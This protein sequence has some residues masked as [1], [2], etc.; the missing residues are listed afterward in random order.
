ME[1]KK[2]LGLFLLQ[3]F[4][5]GLTAC[6]INT[7][8]PQRL[9]A[10]DV[11]NLGKR[12]EDI[13]RLQVETWDTRDPENLREI[14]T[15]DIVHFDDHPA[16][17]GIDEVL[18]MA[19]M[20]FRSFSKW[21]MELGD[22]YISK[23]K[24]V[25]TWVSWDV[26]GFTQDNPGLE[27]DLLETQDNKISFWRLFYDENFGW[28]KID[29]ELLA[30]YEESWSQN[31]ESALLAIY[32]ENATVE[33]TLFGVAT[34][35]HQEIADYAKNIFAL[36]QEAVWKLIIPFAEGKASYP[37]SDEYPFPST[38]GVFGINTKKTDGTVCEIRVV[39][40]LTPNENGKIQ[41]QE[42]FYDANTL[43]ECGWAR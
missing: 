26:F 19:R 36:S 32:S 10:Q 24:C 41:A 7:T 8:Q 33:D 13:A 16:Y 12:C 4:A 22:T 25:G 35:G 30:K 18:S 43:I 21:Q 15:E 20:M 23:E 38:G 3:F 39:V 40:I 29:Y 37:Y 14:Y 34:V 1:N 9:S 2:T 31:D 28:K 27:F 6:S 5:I 11:E 42:T 17:V